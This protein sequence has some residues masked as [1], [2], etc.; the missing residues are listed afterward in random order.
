MYVQSGKAN[1]DN[2]TFA[3]N[4]CTTAVVQ[5]GAISFEGCDAFVNNCLFYENEAARGAAIH[6]DNALA[7]LFG[8]TIADNVADDGDALAC[9]SLYDVSEVTVSNCILWNSGDEIWNNDGSTI[10]VTYS[11]VRGGWTGTGNANENPLFEDATADDYHLSSNSPCIDTGDG[12]IAQ[13]TDAFDVDGQLRVWDGDGNGILCLDMGADEYASHCPAD[14]TGDNVV[15]LADLQILLSSYGT[16][17][18]LSYTDG[19]LDL[20]GDVD[21][22]DLQL[23]LAM[24]G[25]TCGGG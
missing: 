25:T 14:L 16:V 2:C 15:G 22:S 6:C 17:G 1:V 19:D 9:D 20:D 23:L 12:G 11:D 7:D 4:F 24:Y 10:T 3:G 5:G 18:K 8:C 13:E 21:L